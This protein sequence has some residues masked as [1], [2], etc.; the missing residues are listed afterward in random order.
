[1]AA[2]LPDMKLTPAQMAAETK[3]ATAPDSEQYPY[4]LEMH[5]GHDEM[6]KAGM[7]EMPNV[8]DEHL[9]MA[10]ARV[11]HA[12]EESAAADHHSKEPHKHRRVRLQI[13]HMAVAKHGHAD[14]AE[15]LYG[16][17]G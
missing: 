16:K 5:L 4:G 9:I 7:H 13:T 15:T 10:R 3:P 2:E 14:A 12:E 1:M 8:G 6:Q 11:L 17:K